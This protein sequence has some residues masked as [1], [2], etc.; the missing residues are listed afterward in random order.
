MR[1]EFATI[2]QRLRP[3]EKLVVLLNR[4][5]TATEAKV[6]AL[7]ARPSLEYRGVWA[8]TEN[9]SEGAAVTRNGSIF[10]AKA[11]SKGADPRDSPGVWQLAVKSGRDG[12][13][14]K[15]APR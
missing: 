4:A 6:K 7:E 15:D 10:I 13:N 5:A 8:A 12:R 2:K 9:Y 3:V 14:G 11:A 1:R